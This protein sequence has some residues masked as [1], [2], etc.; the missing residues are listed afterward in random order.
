MNTIL[1]ILGTLLIT[2]IIISPFFWLRFLY[3]KDRKLYVFYAMLATVGIFALHIFWLDDY[4]SDFFAKTNSDL[5]YIWY[6]VGFNSIMIGHFFV[7]ISPFI[8]TKIIY[9]RI[10]IK[11]FFVSLVISI[12]IAAVYVFVFVN[13]LLPK[14]FEEL[15]RRL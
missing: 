13:I 11:S 9:E 7:V 14:A 10:S 15:N 1:I 8:F 3:R 5:Y 2:F 6:D 4:F 12:F